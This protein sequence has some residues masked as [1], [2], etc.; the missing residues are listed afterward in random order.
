MLKRP[1]SHL[2]SMRPPAFLL[3][4]TLVTA[5]PFVA[6][7]AGVNRESYM[8]EHGGEHVYDRPMA[9]VWAAAKQLL[10]EEG[11]S[12]R[13]VRGGW[14]YVTEWKESGG[15]SSVASN[16]S[17]YLIEGK[18]LSPSRCTVHFTRVVRSAGASSEGLGQTDNTH[19]GFAPIGAQNT[20]S[21]PL[22]A[23]NESAGMGQK[24][25]ISSGKRDLEMEWRLLGKVDPRAQSAIEAQARREYPD[26]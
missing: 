25:T 16:S 1:L 7:C 10:S 12:G 19:A 9:E 8:H 2:F 13:E 24:S 6:G 23:P 21:K 11:Y 20:D 14:I 22:Q 5:L 4:F 17:R 26:D 15:G 3:A 18:E